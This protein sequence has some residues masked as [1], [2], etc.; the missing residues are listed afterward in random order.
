[1]PVHIALLRAVNLGAH[2]KVAMADLRTMLVAMGFE[3]PR[4]LLHSGNL[5]FRNA[6]PTGPALERS[7]EREAATRLGLETA[8]LVRTAE[9]WQAIVAANPFPDEAVAD[10]GHL[11]LLCLKRPPGRAAYAALGAAIQGRERIRGAGRQV[12]LVYPDGIGTSKLTIALIER[13][14][15][16]VGTG[17]NWNTVRKLAALADG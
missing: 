2:N 3:Q 12:Y 8:F 16:T 11:V 15:G 6:R 4:T 9:E 7:L 1:M 14:L 10:P 5:V 17:R 13:M